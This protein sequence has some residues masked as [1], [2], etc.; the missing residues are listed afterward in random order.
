[1]A[2]LSAL[3]FVEMAV[4]Y[5]LAGSSFNYTLAVSQILWLARTLLA[6]LCIVTFQDVQHILHRL[7][8][9][10]PMQPFLWQNAEL[11]SAERHVISCKFQTPSLVSHCLVQLCTG[12]CIASQVLG[13]YPAFIT[14]TSF[15]V[16]SIL[17]GGAV[18]RSWSS[19]L[20]VLVWNT[21]PC[22]SLST[23]PTALNSMIAT[24][25][26]RATTPDC[27]AGCV[28]TMHIA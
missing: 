26:W 25:G 15:V 18:A 8:S 28:A 10:S 19:Y 4:D 20:A 21:K 14:V 27:D 7:H 12:I 2:F 3:T 6:Q 16:D 5:P 1:M 22:T 17:S 11:L 13:E 23:A 24:Q 9:P